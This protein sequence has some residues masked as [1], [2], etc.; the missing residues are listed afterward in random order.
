MKAKTYIKLGK[1]LF[2]FNRSITGSDLRKSLFFLKRYLPKLKILHIRS[3]KKVFDWKIPN[4][5]NVKNAFI[6]DKNGKKI[7]DFKKNNLHLVAYSKPVKKT[8]NLINLKKKLHFLKKQKYAIPYVTSF[9]KI[10]GLLFKLIINEN[11]KN[12]FT[13]R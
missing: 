6:K 12:I 5:W 3:G 7:L 9:Y 4:E 2:P 11:N 13:K 1:K 10:L 8:L